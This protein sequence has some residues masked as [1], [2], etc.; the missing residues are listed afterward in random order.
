VLCL[1]IALLLG[2]ACGPKKAEPEPRSSAPTRG[3]SLRVLIDAPR[4]L[5]PVGILQ[6]HEATI[7]RQIYEGLV[8]FDPA[9]RIRPSLAS[10]W[11]ISPDGRT[12]TFRLRKG[13]QFHDGTALTSGDVAFTLQ[14]CIA[15]EPGIGCL[16]QT[17]L[18]HIAGAREYRDHRASRVT[19]IRT[20][21][22]A[23]VE[24][25]LEEPLPVFLMV[26]SMD[27]T[28]ILPS[29]GFE[30]SGRAGL[31]EHPNGTGPFRFVERGAGD[32][33]VLARQARYWGGAALLDTLQFVPLLEGDSSNHHTSLLAGRA[34][35]ADI[36]SDRIGEVRKAG[37][38]VYRAPELSLAFLGLRLDRPPLDNPAVRRAMLLAIDRE[39]L[40][41]ADPQGR[42]AATSLLPPGLP[43][44][45]PTDHLPPRSLL[46]A[47]RVLE[48][49]GCPGGTGLP[50][51]RIGF[52]AHP[53]AQRI[54]DGIQADL[55]EIGIEVQGVPLGWSVL[56]SLITSGGLQGFLLSWIADLPDADQ[57]LHSLFHS[58]GEGNMFGYA[59]AEV[60][61]LL[62]A[63]RRGVPGPE[64]IAAV[65]R[66]QEQV[67][68]DAPIIPLFHGASTYAWQPGV[69]GLE[70]GPCGMAIL[71]LHR[72]YWDRA[73]VETRQGSFR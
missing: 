39:K 73:A 35:L 53:R 71:E 34:D 49:A 3:G 42:V 68:A 48:E 72:V 7:L 63:T 56:D 25:E 32:T 8:T 2:S 44:R 38:R 27:Q 26:L 55:R 43:G 5:D 46:E 18:M 65:N 52:S 69:R 62:E 23:T 6:V 31:I 9:L 16:A 20:P 70:I 41:K 37:L 64:H 4:T 45:D 1:G 28:L 50:P 67:I 47:K 60:D 10:S 57:F 17:H 21:D 24:I 54:V 61:Q 40:Q 13:V 12:Y 30:Q 51:I 33:I 66:L 15:P 29:R 58:Q 59:S 14:R 22:A 19:G 36:S 11:T